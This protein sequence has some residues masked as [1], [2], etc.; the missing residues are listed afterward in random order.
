VKLYYHPM[1]TTSRPIMLL[2]AESAID[3]DFELVDVFRGAHLQPE[4]E[5]INPNRQ[6]PVLEDGDFRLTESSAILKYLADKAGSTA[7]PRDPRERA[8]VHEIMDWFNTGLYRDLGY[9]FIYPQLLA[10]QR[11][12]DPHV[13]AATLTWGRDRSRGWLRILDAHVLGPQR[14]WLAGARMT[15]ADYFGACILTVGEVI[16]IDYAA[17]R[18]IQRWLDNVKARPAWRQVNAA[19]Y[20]QFVAPMKDIAFEPF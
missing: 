4:Y 11:R 3:L 12:P 5:R 8:R 6:I 7:Y 17:Y 1:S 2:A 18:N 15:I 10:N 20:A 19:F 14:D 13:Q 16:R 9:G